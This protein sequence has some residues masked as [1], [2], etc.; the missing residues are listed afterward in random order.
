LIAVGMLAGCAAQLPSGGPALTPTASIKPAV[1]VEAP[2]AGVAQSSVQQASVQK[3]SQPEPATDCRKLTG[4]ILIRIEHLKDAKARHQA[5]LLSRTLQS[6]ATPVFG[7]TSYGIDPARD[8]RQ[9]RETIDA[10]NRRLAEKGCKP[11]DVEAE[12]AK[13]D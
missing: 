4:R 1:A 12:L 5:S 3:V 7:G 10:Y 11:V 8:A 13:T 6:V 2:S 9:D